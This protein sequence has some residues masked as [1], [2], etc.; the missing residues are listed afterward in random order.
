MIQ[1]GWGQYWFSENFSQ[2]GPYSRHAW[3]YTFFKAKMGK[4]F[5]P[6]PPP[7]TPALITFKLDEKLVIYHKTLD[8]VR[9]I[10]HPWQIHKEH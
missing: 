6:S 3:I 9:I 4:Y 7:H 2:K 1:P 8:P 5:A 10:I